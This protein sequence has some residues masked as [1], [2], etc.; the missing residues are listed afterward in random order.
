MTKILLV[1]GANLS[2]LG[3]R[4]PA[5][6][7]TTTAAELDLLLQSHAKKHDYAPDIFY[8]NIEGEAINRIYQAVDEGFEGGARTVLAQHIFAM[9][10]QG[11]RDPHP[12][13][14]CVDAAN[15]LRCN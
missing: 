5:I 6:Y 11:E 4:E 2:F 15:T 14:R 7:G 12:H 13:R 8:S 3:R 9:A 1:Q 10:K